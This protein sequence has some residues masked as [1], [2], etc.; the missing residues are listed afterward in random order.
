M[1]SWPSQERGGGDSLVAPLHE[2][3]LRVTTYDV[4]IGGRSHDLTREDVTREVLEKIKGREFDYIFISPPCKSF[5]IAPTDAR[6]QLRSKEHPEGLPTIP[7]E[8]GRYLQRH[9]TMARATIRIIQAAHALGIAWAVENPADR[10]DHGSPAYWRSYAHH[11]TLW[12]I[13]RLHGI[14]NHPDART[15]AN[16]Y[17]LPACSFGADHQKYT[18]IWCSA[19]PPLHD[20]RLYTHACTHQRHDT[21]LQGNHEDGTPRTHHA[22]KYPAEL[23]K[24]LADAIARTISN[25]S[26]TRDKTEEEEHLACLAKIARNKSKQARSKPCI[27]DDILRYIPI[28]TSYR[29]VLQHEYRDQIIDSMVT[30]FEEHLRNKTWSRLVPRTPEMNVVGSTWVWDIKRDANKKL[31]RFKSRL[32]AQG[33]S[34]VKGTDYFRKYSHA[35]SLTTFRLFLA[36]CAS[37]GLLVTEADYTTAYLNAKLDTKIYLRQAEGFEERDEAG[38]LKRGSNGEEMV[39]KVD[40]AIYGLVQSG[41][42]WEE[43]HWGALK[44]EGWEQCASEPTLFKKESDGRPCF[45]CT[46]VDNLFMGFPAESTGRDELLRQLGTKYKINDLGEVKYSLGICARQ[47]LRLHSVIIHQQPLIEEITRNYE[48]DI[49]TLPTTTRSTPYGQTALEDMTRLDPNTHECRLWQHKCLQLA[50]KLNYIAGG[51]R[52]DVA[53]ALSMVMQHVSRASGD[54]Y[55]ALLHIARY[56]HQTANYALHFCPDTP[57][58]FAQNIVNHCDSIKSATGW[59]HNE[60]TVFCDASQGGPRPMMC[61]ITFIAGTPLTW[62]MGR[63]ASTTLSSTEAEWFAQTAGATTLQHLTPTLHFLGNALAKATLSFCDNRSAVLIAEAD[64]SSKRMKHV[65]TRMA[66]LQ[67]RIREGLLAIVHIGREGMLADIGTKRL[68]PAPFHQLRALLVR[69][70]AGGEAPAKGKAAS[71]E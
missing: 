13:L 45:L 31:L 9:N 22:E 32:C 63:L 47:E 39:Y 6:P 54:T 68:A 36:T 40:K 44:A 14:G 48:I 38:N 12:D 25:K 7:P 10:G 71:C 65:L 5:S 55:V 29:Q 42:M 59:T 62:K 52:P 33:F 64:L 2:H 15:C 23:A 8:W 19:H 69:P 16:E 30:E 17:T 20:P 41:L 27:V 49:S 28:P 56:L 26:V 70:H 11:G 53:G 24:V 46:Y 66:Y 37:A 57:L 58:T 50:G 34:Q 60:L 35:M 1:C 21:R 3:G 51:T 61:A 67:E 4:K 43:E 18:T